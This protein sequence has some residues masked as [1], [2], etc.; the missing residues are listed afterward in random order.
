MPVAVEFRD[1][2]SASIIDFWES[3]A[4]IAQVVIGCSGKLGLR[5]HL[6]GPTHEKAL[7]DR[8]SPHCLR[9]D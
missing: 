9:D 7:R 3:V 5:N 2:S 4:E 6:L 1:E 8:R